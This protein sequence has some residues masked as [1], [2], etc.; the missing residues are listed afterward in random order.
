[1]SRLAAHLPHPRV[2]LPPAA[3][4][5]VREIRH[6]LLDLGMKVAQLVA[7]EIQRVEQLAVHVELRLPPGAVAHADWSGV[8]P[9]AQVRQL[10]L[11]QVV[12]AADPVHDLQRA[13]AGPAAG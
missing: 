10:A 12:L 7:V 3:C 11:T 9:A 6:E 5:G 8:A 4:S 13:L 1:M 2:S